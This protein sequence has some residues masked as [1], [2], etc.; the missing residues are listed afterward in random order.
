M[1]SEPPAVGSREA[2]DLLTGSPRFTRHLGESGLGPPLQR[3][4]LTSET[5]E[6]DFAHCVAGHRGP[7]SVREARGPTAKRIR[8]ESGLIAQL[9]ERVADNDEVTG[10]NPVGPI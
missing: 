9:A 5:I 3:A 1:A 2:V 8:K 7:N 4:W 6:V 10:S